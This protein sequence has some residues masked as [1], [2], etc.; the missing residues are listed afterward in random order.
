MKWKQKPFWQKAARGTKSIPPE[1]TLIDNTL[2][3]MTQGSKR[4]RKCLF[5]Y[6]TMFISE[7]WN[8]CRHSYQAA[9]LAVKLP[10]RCYKCTIE[11]R[12]PFTPQSC[13]FSFKRKDIFNDG[14]ISGNTWQ[15]GGWGNKREVFFGKKKKQNNKQTNKPNKYHPKNNATEV[16]SRAGDR[17]IKHMIYGTCIKCG[18]IIRLMSEQFKDNKWTWP[19]EC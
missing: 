10:A 9:V 12:F 18:Y 2:R 19:R 17:L 8:D 1:G 16:G 6:C 11:Q 15:K 7:L 13:I 3:T 14:N 5:K 4:E